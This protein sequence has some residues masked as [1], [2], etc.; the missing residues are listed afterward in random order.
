MTGIGATPSIKILRIV[1]IP[2]LTYGMTS[3]DLT[4]ADKKEIRHVVAEA[5]TLIFE[6]PTS[7][8]LTKYWMMVEAGI[9]DPI[10]LIRINDICAISKAKEGG[11]NITV[12][13]II[14]QDTDLLSSFTPILQE[15]D[16]TW[17][18][19]QGWK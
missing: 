10:D 12:A 8:Y 17:E 18:D 19:I 13:H 5:L 16:T 15:W 9:M 11:I 3:V 6:V 4:K 1:I 2:S 7:T 14:L